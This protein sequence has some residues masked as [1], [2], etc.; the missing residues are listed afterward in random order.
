MSSWLRMPRPGAFLSLIA[1][2]VAAPLAAQGTPT[3]LLVRAVA[4][5]AKIIGS[6]VGG[7]RITVTDVA[8]GTVLA[9]GTQEGGTGNTAAIVRTP[10]E[11]GARVYDTEGAAFWETTLTLSGPTRV[12]VAAE[13]PLDNKQAMQ[14]TSKTILMVPGEDIV[15]EGLIL[16]LNG[17]AVEIEAPAED[18][19]LQTGASLAVRAHVA[20][21]CGCTIQ[22]GGLWDAQ[23]IRVVARLVRD[24]AVMAESTLSYAG[25]PSTFEG[26][27]PLPEAGA[28]R[29]RV[30]A[31]DPERAN[32]GMAEQDITIR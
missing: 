26:S 13:A 15:G 16:E 10:R 4:H 3:R 30:L 14:R 8:T 22:P 12:E 24:G 11:R 20:M 28:Y 31:L 17:F 18:A 21:M 6:S 9:S 2:L 19:S 27:L 25:E 5:D 1:L 32:T 23:R 7:A 29:L